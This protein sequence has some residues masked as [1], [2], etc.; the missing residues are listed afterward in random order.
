MSTSKS[1]MAGLRLTGAIAV[2]LSVAF[3]LQLALYGSGEDGIRAVIR[4]SA[5]TSVVLF[6][7]AFGA[8]SLR[9]VFRSPLAT[10]LVRERRY[11]GLSFAYS[12]LCHL[13]ALIALG[14]VSQA[15]VDSLNAVTLGGGGLAYV[16]LTLMAATSNDWAVKTLGKHNWRRLHT[17]GAYYIWIIF[18]QSYAPRALN[19]SPAYALPTLLL[20]ATMGLRFTAWR[21]AR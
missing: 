16:F 12:H 17:I 10:W 18:F 11:L 5:Q 4:L 14:Q 6:C 7:A 21:Q 15:F 1:S 2:V 8:S 9:V 20:L 3:A 19:V 13:L